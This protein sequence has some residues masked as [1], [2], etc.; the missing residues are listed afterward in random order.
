MAK[1]KIRLELNYTGI[2]QLLKSGEM[3][4]VVE[5]AASQKASMAG[6][7]YTS[8]AHLSTQRWHANVYPIGLDGWRDQLEN[9]TLLKV[10]R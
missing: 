9:N 1:N 10:L 7:D 4:A 2:G 3:K 8:E 6:N 5:S